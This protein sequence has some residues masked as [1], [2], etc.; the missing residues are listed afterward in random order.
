MIKSDPG[1]ERRDARARIFR[2]HAPKTAGAEAQVI[3][4][5]SLLFEVT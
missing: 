4:E 5:Y 3:S 2:W 1:V